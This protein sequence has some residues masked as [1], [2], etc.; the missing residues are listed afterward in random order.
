MLYIQHIRRNRLLT[1]SRERD[2]GCG[3]CSSVLVPIERTQQNKSRSAPFHSRNKPRCLFFCSDCSYV[4][5][6]RINRWVQHFHFTVHRFASQLNQT[7]AVGKLF[8]CS[9]FHSSRTSEQTP[10]HHRV[11][12]TNQPYIVIPHHP[13]KITSF[14]RNTP[15]TVL[16]GLHF[17]HR[18]GYSISG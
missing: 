17:L 1:S 7:E 5:P 3:V 16:W 6:S 4:N 8:C 14:P 15:K 12:C 9:E 18:V 2:G 11:D 13:S 10:T